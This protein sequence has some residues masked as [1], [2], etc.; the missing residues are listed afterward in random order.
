MAANTDAPCVTVS[1]QKQELQGRE[2]KEGTQT[3]LAEVIEPLRQVAEE[4]TWQ[5]KREVVNLDT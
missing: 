5:K 4:P 2:V 3:D 1:P